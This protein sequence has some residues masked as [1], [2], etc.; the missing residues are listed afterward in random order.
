MFPVPQQLRTLIL[1]MGTLGPIRIQWQR[2]G[3]TCIFHSL[4]SY[5][6][7]AEKG[8]QKVVDMQ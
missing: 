2:W 6:I 1:K 7:I 5:R 4:E 8:P 3:H